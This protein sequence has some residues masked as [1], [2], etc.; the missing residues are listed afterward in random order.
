MA[1]NYNDVI[2]VSPI[3]FL[4]GLSLL[5]LIID[6]SFKKSADALYWVT[7][8][9]LVISGLLTANTY[10]APGAAFNGSVF[11][12]KFPAFFEMVFVV[13]A[14][15][16]VLLSKSYLEREGIHFG[17]YYALIIFATV[18][19]MLMA[20]ARD[21]MVLFIGL[22]LMSISLYVLAGFIRRDAKSN[23]ASLKY[24]LLGAFAT[25]FFLFGISLVYGASGTTNLAAILDKF[26]SIQNNPILWIGAALILIGLSFKISAVPFHMWVPD[27]YEGSPTTVS[28]FMST[29]SK[30]AAFSALVVVFNYSVHP[31]WEIRLVIAYLA[32]ATMVLGNIVAL[33]QQNIKRMLAYSSIAHAGYALVGI[34]S[35]NEIGR[36]G[37]LYYMLAYTFM[38]IGAFGVVSI[39]ENKEGKYLAI[40]DY[41]GL[42]SNHPF[43]S[44]LMALFMFSLA[45]IPPFAGFFGKYYL[46]ASAVTANMT[47]LAVVGVL[48]SVVSVYFYI[49]VV[50]NM[51]FSERTR[52]G[53]DLPEAAGRAPVSKLAVT[54]LIIAALS[55]I[56]L[57]IA[58][59]YVVAFT[60][61]LF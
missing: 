3:I 57:G 42:C 35:A 29:G 5:V 48:A 33:V 12:G 34:A 13:S 30:A 21:L 15:L 36:T 24:F 51:Y 44:A 18:G 6:V 38:Q 7:I 19:M 23:E 37:V 10:F 25:G 11:T 58:P 41:A 59:A 32:A 31:S 16:S 27:V 4:S 56:G 9:G 8:L 54:A 50:V 26:A 49:N 39:L 14:I 46:F 40:S 53:E 45:G 1:F 17:E 52:S 47:W 2:S 22:E 43:I 61:K 20:S 55:V 28:G 60:E